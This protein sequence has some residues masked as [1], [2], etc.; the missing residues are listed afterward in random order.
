VFLGAIVVLAAAGAL[1]PIAYVAL[2]VGSSLLTSW[3]SAGRYPML[4]E[5]GGQEGSPG[6][7]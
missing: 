7:K 3:G 2:L 1:S 5:F 4:A 6:P